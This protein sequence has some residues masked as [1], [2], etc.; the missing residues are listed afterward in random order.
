MLP[1]QNLL[2]GAWLELFKLGEETQEVTLAG[3]DLI[4]VDVMDSHFVPNITIG[5]R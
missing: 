4:H 3:A 1:F 5:L 2:V